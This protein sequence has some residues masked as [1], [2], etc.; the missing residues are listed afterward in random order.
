MVSTPHFNTFD[1]NGLYIAYK[2]DTLKDEK[3][4]NV[5]VKDINF[6]VS[7]F[8]MET[9]CSLNDGNF[10]EIVDPSTPIPFNIDNGLNISNLNFD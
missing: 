9:S 7:L 10:P 5:I 2:N 8:C 3:K 1:Q 6:G 4:S